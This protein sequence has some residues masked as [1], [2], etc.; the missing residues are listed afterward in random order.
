M[1]AESIVSC[2][3]SPSFTGTLQGIES[4]GNFKPEREVVDGDSYIFNTD[5]NAGKHWFALLYVDCLWYLLDCSVLTPIDDHVKII[6]KLHHNVVLQ[7]AQLQVLD[8]MTCGE[9]SIC[10]LYFAMKTFAEMK[11]LKG[12]N[13]YRL[14]R[15]VDYDKGVTPDQLVSD[16]IHSSNFKVQK[17]DLDSVAE[18]LHTMGL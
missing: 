3:T 5:I 11:T 1:D 2:L 4:V 10:F 6:N 15:N 8:S 12:L 13:Y 17:P 9:H 16:F 7:V 18:W 14:L